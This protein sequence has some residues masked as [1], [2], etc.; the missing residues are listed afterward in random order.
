MRALPDV[1]TTSEAGLPGVE[2]TAWYALFAPKGTDRSRVEQLAAAVAATLRQ[3]AF[4]AAL[5]AR[6]YLVRPTTMAQMRQFL[7]RDLVN[8]RRP[9][10]ARPQGALPG[11]PAVA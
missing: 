11:L 9:P 2:A 7:Q 8:W 3:P 6:G 5:E 4:A 1:P 10:P